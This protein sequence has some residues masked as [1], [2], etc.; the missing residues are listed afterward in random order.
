MNIVKSKIAP[1]P[2]EVRY[3]ADLTADKYGRIIKIFDGINWVPFNA[4]GGSGGT[5]DYNDLVNKPS[6]NGVTLMGNVALNTLDIQAASEMDKY[7][8][9]TEV[10]SLIPEEY[11]TE[12]ELSDNTYSKEEIADIISNVEG[13]N[14][15][16]DV[17]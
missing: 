16:N 1:N 13:T 6:I 9:D 15:W 7:A 10:P 17:Q 11:I 4:A 12:T 5:S 2:K 14:A 3:W 8:E